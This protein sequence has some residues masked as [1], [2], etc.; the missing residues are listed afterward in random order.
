[1]EAG[2]MLRKGDMKS[3]AWIAAYERNNVLVGLDTACAAAPRSARAC[4]PCP[5]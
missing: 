1:M 4:G 5:T 2:P 3:T